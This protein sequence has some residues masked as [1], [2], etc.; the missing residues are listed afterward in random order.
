MV[1][2]CILHIASSLLLAPYGI[3]CVYGIKAKLDPD[4]SEAELSGEERGTFI[5]W[6]ARSLVLFAIVST[7]RRLCSTFTLLLGSCR[8]KKRLT[9]S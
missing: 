1:T 5:A 8:V 7:A 6:F 3:L 9:L 2:T 4:V